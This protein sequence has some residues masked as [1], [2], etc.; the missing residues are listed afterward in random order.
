MMCAR[1]VIHEKLAMEL[2]GYR[3]RHVFDRYNISTDKDLSD[4]GEKLA[5]YLAGQRNRK[6][7]EMVTIGQNGYK[8]GYSGPFWIAPVSQVSPCFL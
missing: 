6:Q 3:T 8:N 2:S 5:Q 1:S 4:A 7:R